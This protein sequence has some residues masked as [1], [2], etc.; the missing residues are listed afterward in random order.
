MQLFYRLILFQICLFALPAYAQIVSQFTWDSN[1]VTQALIGPNASS[2]GS[3]A[4][5]SPGGTAGTNGLNPGSPKAD[6]N[7]IIPGS[8]TF[9][10]T[11]IDISIDYQRQES[12]ADFFTRGAYFNLSAGSFFSVS[13]R[14]NNGSGGFTTVNSGNVYAIPNDN[15]FRRYRFIYLPES[16]RGILMVDDVEVWSFDGPDNRDLYWEGSGDVMIGRSMDASGANTPTID[17]LVIAQTFFSALPIELLSFEANQKND[18]EVELFWETAS[19]SQND[20][21]TIERSLDGVDWSE[22]ARLNG[23]GN[24]NQYLSYTLTDTNVPNTFVYYRLKQTD[25]NGEFSLSDIEQVDLSRTATLALHAYPNPVINVLTVTGKEKELKELAVY[26]QIGQNITALINI[27]V[28]NKEIY[29]LNFSELNSGYYFLKTK[30]NT[31]KVL[32]H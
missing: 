12:K 19:E 22:V 2:V 26:N 1:L 30:S 27:S 9:D 7:M 31:K 23:A 11:G 5:S 10:L 20:Y 17:N 29:L 6:I 25:F 18:N 32:K 16:G 13:Y 24:S 4:I 28:L 15:I 3:S 8:P 14:V 21:F